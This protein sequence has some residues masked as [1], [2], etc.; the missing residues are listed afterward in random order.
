MSGRRRLGR[1]VAALLSGSWRADPDPAHDID[2]DELRPAGVVLIGSGSGG[3]AWSRLRNTRFA[4]DSVAARLHDIYRVQTLEA[5]LFERRLTSAWELF[6]SA[7]LDP[8]LGKG[9]AVARR[10]PAAGLR[11][12]GDIDLF[13]EPG[14]G[15]AAQEALDGWSGQYLGVDIHEGVPDLAWPWE[16]A[17]ARAD[18]VRLN[19]VEISI[20]SDTDHLVLLSTHML[21]HGAWRPTW[22]CDVALWTEEAAGTV[23]WDLVRGLPPSE[24]DHV[25]A[26]VRLA[27]SLLGATLDEVPAD[28]LGASLPAW[29]GRSALT[30]WGRSGHYMHTDAVTL[31]RPTAGELVEALRVRWPNAIEA[32]VR[33]RGRFDRKP[34]LPYQL[35][36][37][38]ARVWNAERPG[39]RAPEEDLDVAG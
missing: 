2:P 3:L 24:R 28:V 38:A 6:G 22:L 10:Y 15:A 20:L 23:D 32:T 14:R 25:R 29:V 8:L 33:W 21:R 37:V 1:T 27:G 16:E 18:R 34:R 5:R 4:E 39:S 36:D 7:G 13:F 9:W 11:P 12:S 17:R 30:A 31:G 35:V 26:A 19:G